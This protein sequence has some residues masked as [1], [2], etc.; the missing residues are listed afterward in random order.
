MCTERD[1][2]RERGGGDA[3]FV[4]S[5]PRGFSNEIWQAKE[6]RDR[7]RVGN[8]VIFEQRFIAA[9][10]NKILQSQAVALAESKFEL[11]KTVIGLGKEID[12]IRDARLDSERN[13]RTL[14]DESRKENDRVSAIFVSITIF[15]RSN[16]KRYTAKMKEEGRKIRD[17]VSSFFSYEIID[18]VFSARKYKIPLSFSGKILKVG[19]CIRDIHTF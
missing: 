4:C 11:E 19:F 14:L 16:R 1:K 17:V 8:S 13:T 18:F 5:A 9:G 6:G 10:E 12:D 15:L 3:P 7:R 2:E